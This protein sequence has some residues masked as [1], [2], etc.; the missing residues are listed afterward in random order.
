[1]HSRHSHP[2]FNS[3]PV[4][5]Q[6]KHELA[7]SPVAT[8]VPAMDA[9]LAT[10]LPRRLPCE[11]CQHQLTPGSSSI[12]SNHYCARPS[13]RPRALQTLGG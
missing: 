3:Q 9:N 5:S 12:T 10:L 1:M 8:H 4:A 11:T 7:K 2:P 13:P 6:N